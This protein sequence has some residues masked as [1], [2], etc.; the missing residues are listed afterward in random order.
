MGQ[1]RM[2]T[3]ALAAAGLTAQIRKGRHIL[4]TAKGITPVS[5]GESDGRGE[6]CHAS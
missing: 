1:A 2:V 6:V 5:L 4:T 3:A